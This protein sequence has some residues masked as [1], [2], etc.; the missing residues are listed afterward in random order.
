M[1]YFYAMTALQDKFFYDLLRLKVTGMPKN[2]NEKER[3][4]ISITKQQPLDIVD[5]LSPQ[6]QNHVPIYSN[7]CFF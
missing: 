1:L 5:V 2:G 3:E 7:F 6:V 4:K